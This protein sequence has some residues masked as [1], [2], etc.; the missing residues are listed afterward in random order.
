M[1][2]C[3]CWSALPRK[4]G[5]VKVTRYRSPLVSTAA[6]QPET[7]AE[8]PF[9]S[10]EAVA[11]S[12]RYGLKCAVVDWS[13]SGIDA[14]TMA[15]RLGAMG[16]EQQKLFAAGGTC[17]TQQDSDTVASLCALRPEGIVVVAK[18]WEPPLLE[19]LDFLRAIR[20][21]CDG[22]QPLIVLLWGGADGVADADIE[23]W[24]VTLRQLENPDLH[25]EVM[26]A[27]R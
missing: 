24:R 20:E 22:P 13:G 14:D 11:E 25:L 19:F 6:L 15:G 4:A 3:A 16:I 12:T 26:D 1:R 27:A 7:A 10:R 18:S 21:R 23:T 9:A 17:S 2:H 8:I 5:V